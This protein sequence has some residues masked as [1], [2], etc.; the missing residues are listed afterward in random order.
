[1]YNVV[2]HP[3]F[4]ILHSNMP[5]M[6]VVYFQLL[7]LPYQNLK[8]LRHPIVLNTSTPQLTMNDEPIFDDYCWNFRYL[9][10][11]KW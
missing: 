9:F 10:C 2:D 7:E 11:F 5:L 6:L 4:L 1:M 8:S 3:E